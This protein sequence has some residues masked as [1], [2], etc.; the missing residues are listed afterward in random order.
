MKH[1]M[2]ITRKRR[3]TDTTKKVLSTRKEVRP[4]LRVLT[5]AYTQKVSSL[6]VDTVETAEVDAV[7]TE[8][9]TTSESTTLMRKDSQLSRMRRLITATTHQ[10][11][12]NSAEAEVATV[13]TEATVAEE[14]NTVEVTTTVALESTENAAVEAEVEEEKPA[15]GPR[16]ST[17]A[18][19][20]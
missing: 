20:M 4:T 10:E 12:N 11:D 17:E 5:R 16:K 8:A 18:E 13:A 19:A 7:V 9:T 2:L 6:R 15:H 1:L 3:S 14:E